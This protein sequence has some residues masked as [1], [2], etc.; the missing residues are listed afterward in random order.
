MRSMSH[1]D[2]LIPHPFHHTTNT[3]DSNIQKLGGG[4]I[5]TDNIH[6]Y[7]SWY[8]IYKILWMICT[9]SPLMN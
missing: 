1:V 6:V 2:S 8:K 3:R 7:F 5:D 9:P 4:G